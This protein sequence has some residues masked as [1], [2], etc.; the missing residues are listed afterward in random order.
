MSDDKE[1]TL[2]DIDEV[3]LVDEETVAVPVLGEMRE[4]MI[5][6]IG[7]QALGFAMAFMAERLANVTYDSLLKLYRTR[8][9]KI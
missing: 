2:V 1:R 5:H 4:P 6:Q 3:E 8:K 7:R 9:Y